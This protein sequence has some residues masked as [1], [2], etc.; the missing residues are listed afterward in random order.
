MFVP[1]LTPVWGLY[2]TLLGKKEEVDK[3]VYGQDIGLD[4]KKAQ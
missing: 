1:F 2:L 3:V 4:K